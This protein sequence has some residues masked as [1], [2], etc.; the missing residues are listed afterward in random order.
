[1]VGAWSV[2][3]WIVEP[4][5]FREDTFAASFAGALGVFALEGEEGF[6]LFAATEAEG[7]EEDD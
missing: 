1:M 3:L 6:V 7:G 4:C 2:H 5:D